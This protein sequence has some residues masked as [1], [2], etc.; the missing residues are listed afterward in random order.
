MSRF[1]IAGN[2]FKDCFRGGRLWLL[3]LVANLIL[4]ALLVAWLLVPVASNLH[5]IVNF[6]FASVLIVAVLWLHGGTL[7]Y[8]VDR[9]RSESAPLWSAF[10]RALSHLIPFAVCVAVL[11]LLWLL[12]GKLDAYQPAFPAYLRS[13]LPVSIRRHVTLPALD[14]LF[15]VFLFVIRWILAPGLLLPF[16]AQTA[17]CGF[18]GFGPQGFYAWKKTVSSVAYWLVLLIAALLGV[19]AT[20][21]LM[22]WT[23]D[24][25]TSTFHSEAISFAA[26]FFFAYV[27]GLFSWMLACSVVGRCNA[28]AGS[29]R[30]VAGNPAA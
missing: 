8:F 28:A 5:L 15:S 17:D 11:C 10:R 12:V 21:K 14:T 3:Q 6:V 13:T 26:R 24:F 20:Q 19:F 9:Q 18:R 27:F 30:N 2:S 16:F 1:E 29:S 23:P 22:A 25:K 4:L 7:N